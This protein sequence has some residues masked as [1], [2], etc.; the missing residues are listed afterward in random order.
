MKH[1]RNIWFHI[2]GSSADSLCSWSKIERDTL[3]TLFYL[4]HLVWTKTFQFKEHNKFTQCLMYQ[5]D[6]L[7]WCLYGNK[8]EKCSQMN[9]EDQKSH[10][11][12][13]RCLSKW[14]EIR[15]S[16][17][18]LAAVHIWLDRERILQNTKLTPGKVSDLYQSHKVWGWVEGY[19]LPEDNKE[20]IIKYTKKS[21]KMVISQEGHRLSKLMVINRDKKMPLRFCK[22]SEKTRL[23][24]KSRLFSW[25]LLSTAGGGVTVQLSD[26]PRRRADHKA[27][28][29]L[30]Y[31]LA[32]QRQ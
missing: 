6:D 22:R 9:D 29:K 10:S 18:I 32:K 5:V 1:F 8:Q 12:D 19:F 7:L 14:V 21:C 24:P 4:V 23:P 30:K 15:A 26:I 25:I 27:C 31:D 2:P 28:L 20:W 3:A 16:E 13:A 17:G 11:Q